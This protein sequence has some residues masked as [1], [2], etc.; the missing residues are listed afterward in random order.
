M[1]RQDPKLDLAAPAMVS[2]GARFVLVGGF[3]VIAN[4]FVRAT[5]DIDFSFPTTTRTTDEC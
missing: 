5:E 1:E 4:R 2:A 3:A